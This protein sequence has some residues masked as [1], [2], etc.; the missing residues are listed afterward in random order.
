ML[1]TIAFHAVV[2]YGSP[3]VRTAGSAFSATTVDVGLAP[4]RKDR[5]GTS[6]AIDADKPGGAEIASTG[7]GAVDASAGAPAVSLPVQAAGTSFAP[8]GQ[9]AWAHSR[10]LPLGARAPPAL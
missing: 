4:K 6:D 7:S 8:T 3:V 2:P 9:P 1:L 10:S 5:L